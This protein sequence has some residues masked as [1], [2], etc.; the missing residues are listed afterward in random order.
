MEMEVTLRPAGPADAEAVAEVYLA[1]RGAFVGFAPLAHSDAEVRRWIA[2]H[3]I[4]SGA[5]TVAVQ[6]AQVVGLL[7][8]SREDGTGWI[9]Q[10]YLAPGFV[11]NGIGVR[12]LNSAKIALGPPIRLYTFQANAGSRRFYERHG[13]HA[14]AVSDGTDNEENCPDVLYEWASDPET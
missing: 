12:L 7:A 14:I 10:L 2:E 5:A 1:S 4:Q 9:D 8:V 6:N 13:F 3:L 11:G